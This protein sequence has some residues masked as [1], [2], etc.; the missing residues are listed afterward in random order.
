[1][2]QV[3][4]PPQPLPPHRPRPL[5]CDTPKDQAPSLVRTGP[6]VRSAPVPDP[7]ITALPFSTP[8]TS[9]TFTV[10]SGHSS[11]ASS[12]VSYPSSAHSPV[13]T[14]QFTTSVSSSDPDVL[15]RR[16]RELEKQLS[17]EALSR[18]SNLGSSF[19]PTATHES[20]L[21][22]TFVTQTASTS[23]TVNVFHKSR[24]F[25]QSH[26]FNGVILVEPS[27]LKGLRRGRPCQLVT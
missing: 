25:G 8:S 2:Y 27:R 4:Q 13:A 11:K 19:N 12:C 6:V 26:W 7:L 1:M 18:S 17:K 24:L 3:R 15:R 14:N 22:G 10:V 20:S 23:R 16:I 5:A 9:E 21:A